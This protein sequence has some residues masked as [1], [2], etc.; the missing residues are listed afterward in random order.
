MAGDSRAGAQAGRSGARIHRG[1][2]ATQAAGEATASARLRTAARR[3][4]LA[5]RAAQVGR[6]AARSLAAIRADLRAT[7][8][9]PVTKIAQ[10]TALPDVLAWGTFVITAIHVAQKRLATVRSEAELDEIVRFLGAVEFEAA[11]Y[12]PATAESLRYI[13]TT[14]IA[15]IDRSVGLLDAYA[16]LIA[17]GANANRVYASSLRR[18]AGRDSYLVQLIEESHALTGAA[19]RSS[20]GC[21]DRRRGRRCVCRR[22]CSSTWRPPSWS[23]T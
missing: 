12:M 23:T 8:E 4:S 13:G 9:T 15:D 21:V 14:S 10:L 17:Y 20:K 5:Q 19:A 6:E 3:T 11:T 22:R 18:A 1:A 7:A 16:G 2:E